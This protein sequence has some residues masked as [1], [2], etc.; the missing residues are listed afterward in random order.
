M[1]KHVIQV[2]DKLC[3]HRVTPHTALS[4]TFYGLTDDGRS[5]DLHDGVSLK[6]ILILSSSHPASRHKTSTHQCGM[7]NAVQGSILGPQEL[8]K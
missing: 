1:A 6:E 8:I 3:C 4:Q 2:E 7:S 5:G